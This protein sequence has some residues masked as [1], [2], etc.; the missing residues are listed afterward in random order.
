MST[1]LVAFVVGPLEAT[2]PVDV[3][4]V[5]LRVV[6][7]LGKAH[8]AP[9]ALEIGASALRTFAAYYG[10][11]YP[12][13]KVDLVAIPDFAFGAMENLGCITFRETALLVDPES[14]TQPELERVADVVAHELAHMWFGDLVTMRWWNGIWLN[15]AFATFMEVMAVDRFRPDW[16]RWSTFALGRSAAFDTDALTT[17]RPIE[18]P[19]LSP[20]DAEGMFD[21]LTYEKGASVV[22]MLEQYLGEPTFKAGISTY[23][24]THAYGNTE[25]S[26]LWDALEAASG[27][28][29]RRVAD[30][31]I[32]QGGHPIVTVERSDDPTALKLW[33]RPFRYVGGDDPARWSVPIGLRWADADGATHE[34]DVLLESDETTI[35]LGSEPAWVVANR[36]AAG[37]FRTSYAPDLHRALAE[38]AVDVLDPTERYT[39]LDDTWAA[40]IADVAPFREVVE[41]IDALAADDDLSVWRRLLAVLATLHRVASDADRPAVAARVRR[42]VGPLLER[43]GDEPRTGE[44]E[45]L[46]NLRAAAFE[47]IGLFG[48][49]P[50]ARARAATLVERSIGGNP[51]GDDPSL[52]D[53]A[54]RIVAVGADD[55]TFDR[56]LAA[57]QAAST[58]Q[59][60]LRYLG[61]LADVHD[62]A[63]FDRFTVLLLSD[64]VRSQDVALLLSRA[65]ANRANADRA[66]AATEANWDALIARLPSNAVSRMVTGVRTVTDPALAQ[67]VESFLDAHPIPQAVK[68]FSQHRERMQV[69]VALAER[70]HEQLG[71]VLAG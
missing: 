15:E 45:R 69:T 53:A 65:L 30:S 59:D 63:V 54:V 13:D 61:A 68:A 32:F 23:L 37:F 12:G 46:T 40:V 6:H 44:P 55:A 10:I 51:A 34:I 42:V 38:V 43:L 36:A 7:P 4:G 71:S 64:E 67:R 20:A 47:A 41:L 39:L 31:W 35:D 24:T 33:Q 22:R 57:S 27:Q 52:T 8:L 60:R 29:V 17:T 58:P 62:P 49:D 21:I 9:F 50:D 5:P 56:F 48:D 16:H 26:D 28:P 70:A 14:A 11:P 1:Y 25:T 19:V 66:W 18:Y 3:D 2:P